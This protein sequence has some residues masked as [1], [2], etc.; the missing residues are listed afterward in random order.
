MN[1]LQIAAGIVAANYGIALEHAL[2]EADNL[3]LA[4][5]RSTTFVMPDGFT[6]ARSN[7][8]FIAKAEDH[9]LGPFTTEKQAVEAAW[10]LW[11]YFVKVDS[12]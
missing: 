8:G 10:K 9:R 5:G 3:L 1:R 12:L 2:A 11:A 7:T 4:A 6:M